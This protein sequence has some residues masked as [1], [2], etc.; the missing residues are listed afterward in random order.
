MMKVS[1]LCVALLLLCFR[2]PERNHETVKQFVDSEPGVLTGA[3]QLSSF[4]PDLKGKRV[5]LVA[6]N[7][8]MVG[9]THLA[10]T[11][12]RLNVNLVKI[13][14]PE[15]GFRGRIQNGDYV[16]DELDPELQIPVVS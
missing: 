8:A 4:I 2:C 12:K 9:P 1:I 10:D 7:T 5:A 11:L 13:F 14:A 15:H 6:N 3:D 16:K